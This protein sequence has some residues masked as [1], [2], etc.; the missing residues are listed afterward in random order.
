MF[1]EM[2]D[3]AELRDRRAGPEFGGLVTGDGDIIIEF[4]QALKLDGEQLAVPARVFGKL[5]VGDDIGAD[6]GLG[7]VLEANGRDLLYAEQLGR[8]DAAMTGD[9]AARGVDQHGVGPTEF[10]DAVGDLADL[11]LRVSPRVGRPWFQI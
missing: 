3:I 8:L 6:L 1:A 9:D 10:F 4:D 11:L 2:P 5:I 7:Q